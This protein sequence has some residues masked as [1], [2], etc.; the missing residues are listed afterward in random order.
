MVSFLDCDGPY[1]LK[2]RQIAREESPEAV[3]SAMM[4]Q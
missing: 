1:Y 3:S 4:S 2:L